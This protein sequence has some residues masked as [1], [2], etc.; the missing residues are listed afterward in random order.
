MNDLKEGDLLEC[1]ET[2]T[3]KILTVGKIYTFNYYNL[4]KNRVSVKE[5]ENDAFFLK[6]FKKY[7]KEK[8]KDMEVKLPKKVIINEDATILFWS[9]DRTDKTMVKLT[10]D[11]KFDKRLGFLYAYFQKTS[12]LTRSKANKYIEALK[13]I[14]SKP[15]KVD[16]DN[17]KV[18]VLRFIASTHGIKGYYKLNKKELINK[19]KGVK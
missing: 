9:D 2:N 19:L 8:E 15:I 14:P 13:V 16:Y 10:K 4:S 12:G 11:D 7:E 1:I 3:Y 17:F 5:H 6:R 18:P